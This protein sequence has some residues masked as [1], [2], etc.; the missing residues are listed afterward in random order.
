[1]ERMLVR[2]ILRLWT[3]STS[4]PGTVVTMW[5]SVLRNRLDLVQLG[6]E[7]SNSEDRDTAVKRLGYKT[8]YVQ[9]HRLATV[10]D[11]ARWRAKL[12][13]SWRP[14]TLA[15]IVQN[16]KSQS[17]L[18]YVSD[19]AR[20][21]H[22]RGGRVFLTFP[23]NWNVLTTWPIQSMISEAPFLCAREGKKGILTNCVDTARLVGRSRCCKSLVSQ[24][25]VQ[26]SLA[27]LFVSREVCLWNV[28]IQE[29]S[30]QSCHHLVDEETTAFPSEEDESMREWRQEFPEKMRRA[31]IRIHTNL[32]HPQNSR[33]AK[34]ISDAGGSEEMIK[35]ANRYPCSVCKRMSRPVSDVL[36]Q[37]QEPDSSM[38]LCWLMCI[39]G[40]FEAVRFW[41]TR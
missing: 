28:S 38:T 23:W 40:I 14:V 9:Q 5:S 32:G 17:L 2:P 30:E 35:C 11:R 27:N 15:V 31:I 3:P 41:C 25:L 36:C 7:G 26:S 22:R 1:M 6:G 21:Q 20:D 24:R 29:D 12:E 8:R 10:S 39:S 34:M 16:K 37:F 33:L 4:I 19:L 18:A 13:E